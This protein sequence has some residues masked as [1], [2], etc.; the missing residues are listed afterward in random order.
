MQSVFVAMTLLAACHSIPTTNKCPHQYDLPTWREH[1]GSFSPVSDGTSHHLNRLKLK[2]A[3]LVFIIKEGGFKKED[4]TQMNR[5]LKHYG[6]N[7]IFSAEYV[8]AP[9]E[10][11]LFSQAYEKFQLLY[12]ATE[13]V[14]NDLLHHDVDDDIMRLWSD[15]SNLL[16][17]IIKNIYTEFVMQEVEPISPLARSRIPRSLKCIEHSAYRDTRDFVILR[18]LLTT[19]QSSLVIFSFHFHYV[20]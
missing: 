16:L 7:D 13:V 1:S 2:M 20:L 12:L 17:D 18:H 10:S 5:D 6:Y 19:L 3:S 14:Q 11:S 9:G 4:N 15:I 8:T